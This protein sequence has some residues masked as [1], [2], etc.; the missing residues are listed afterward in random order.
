MA[1]ICL[2]SPK[3]AMEKVH[4]PLDVMVSIL[5]EHTLERFVSIDQK[6]VV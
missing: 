3:R 2:S 1:Y 5:I 6:N 4:V